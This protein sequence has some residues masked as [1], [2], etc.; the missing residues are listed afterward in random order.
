MPPR[1]EAAWSPACV[2]SPADAEQYTLSIVSTRVLAASACETVGASAVI[3]T[4][5]NPMMLPIFRRRR[6]RMKCCDRER[7]TGR[8]CHARYVIER[9]AL[10]RWPRVGPA[11]TDRPAFER[12]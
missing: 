11:L 9:G 4:A 3:R 10:P 2:R 1:Y 12:S 5:S 8:L 6:L 7:L